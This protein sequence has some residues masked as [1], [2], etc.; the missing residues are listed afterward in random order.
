MQ[1]GLSPSLRGRVRGRFQSLCSLQI[2]V[3]GVLPNMEGNAVRRE[4]REEDRC[5]RPLGVRFEER[6][7]CR[8]AQSIET[9]A[10]AFVRG[11]QAARLVSRQ[12]DTVLEYCTG[13]WRELTGIGVPGVESMAK[14]LVH[15]RF[16]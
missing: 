16:A 9:L 15:W 12:A 3:R 2:R 14:G 5:L 7:V 1:D 8:G 13:R 11:E 10:E 6:E 4:Q